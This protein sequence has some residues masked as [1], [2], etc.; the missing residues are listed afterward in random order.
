MVFGEGKSEKEG[1]TSIGVELGVIEA[2]DYGFDGFN[3]AVPWVARVSGR[4]RRRY[5]V[6]L[7]ERRGGENA[8]LEVTTNEEL[9]AHDCGC[10]CEE[11]LSRGL[12][13]N[14]FD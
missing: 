2:F 7:V 4:V 9:T 13:L 8:H 14:G 3:G 10:G 11:D 12:V 6:A 1:C 5:F